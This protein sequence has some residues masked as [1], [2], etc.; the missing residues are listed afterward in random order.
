MGY[1]PTVGRFAQRDP[2]GYRD[3]M[4]QLE[5]VGGR[6][7]NSVDPTG[8][9][10][11]EG[12][13]GF[14]DIELGVGVKAQY[15][16]VLGA[17]SKSWK[18]IVQR[19][20]AHAIFEDGQGHQVGD[21]TTNGFDTWHID[22]LF[23]AR[24]GAFGDIHEFQGFE[25][26]MKKAGSLPYCKFRLLM[27]SNARFGGSV[28]VVE[29]PGGPTVPYDPKNHKS[30]QGEPAPGGMIGVETYGI[31]QTNEGARPVRDLNGVYRAS[32]SSDDAWNSR[33]LEVSS[34]LSIEIDFASK[35]MKAKRTWRVPQGT[36][37]WD[38][39][40]TYDGP[41][42]LDKGMIQWAN[43]GSPSA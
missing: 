30:I 7:T 23:E 24:N 11:I 21:I 37:K 28:E 17:E 15:G 1:H 36:R 13:R 22:K 12:I 35:K 32:V 5:Y 18:Y 8:T 6:V 4:N 19:V 38:L 2:E 10:A 29:K 3:G 31:I 42:P 33:N 16:W 41:Y 20:T 25:A 14:R 39:D 26:K 40:F 27:E 43:S 34:S 9:A